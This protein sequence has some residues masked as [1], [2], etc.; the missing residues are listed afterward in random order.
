M[1][2]AAGVAKAVAADAAVTAAVNAALMSIRPTV[3]RITGSSTIMVARPVAVPR[4]TRPR[5]IARPKLA[6]EVKGVR[7]VDNQLVVAASS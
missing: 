1:K 5:A 6:S 4:R 2:E 3:L 7:N